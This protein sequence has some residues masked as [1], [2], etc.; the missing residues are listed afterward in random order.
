MKPNSHRAIHKHFTA[1]L[2]AGAVLLGAPLCS[3][4]QPLSTS[5]HPG[6]NFIANPFNNGGNSAAVIFPNPDPT[7]D[8]SGP[9]DNDEIR[10]W[11]CAGYIVY[12]FDSV[13]TDTTSGFVNQSGNPA[14]APILTPG[15]GFV[16]VD[17]QGAPETLV[18][19]GTAP[20]PVRPPPCNCGCGKLSLWS[21][22]TTSSPHGYQDITGSA[23]A[24]GDQ[25][26]FPLI[27]GSGGLA[28]F[29][30][31]TYSSGAWSP[32]TPTLTNGQS[33]FFYSPCC[34]N[35]V[36]VNLPPGFSLIGNPLD[37]GNNSAALLFPN[38]DPTQDYSGPRDGDELELWQC[39][40]QGYVV[41]VFDS[42]TT[43]TTTGFTNPNGIPIPA[44]ILTP[45]CGFLYLN[46]MGINES[47]VFTGCPPVAV[48]PPP[49]DCGCGK[50]SLWTPQTLNSPHSYQDVTGSAPQ[51]GDA[52]SYGVSTMGVPIPTDTY[53]GGVWS[54]NTP[55]F[56]NGES[57]FFYRP[58]PTNCVVLYDTGVDDT[59]ALLNPGSVD[60]HYT[61]INNPQGT[62][63]QTYVIVNPTAAWIPNDA[64][65]Q[66]IGPD[67]NG[68]NGISGE[69]DF[70]TTFGVPC[71]GDVVITG[72]WAAD[73]YGCIYLDT[74][75]N[76]VPGT[77]IGSAGPTDHSGFNQWHPFTVSGNLSAGTH[78][79]TFAV[80][81]TGGPTGL[82]VEFLTVTGGCCTDC[83]A[84]CT[85]P[86]PLSY[87]NSVPGGTSFL[88]NNLC[89][90]TNNTLDEILP[91]MPDSVELRTWDFVT[92]N[93]DNPQAYDAYGFVLPSPGWYD[94]GTLAPSTTTLSPGEGF[95]INNPNGPFQI[96]I[97]GCEPT[98]PPPCEPPTN[99]LSLVGRLGIGTATWTNLF[100]CP[101]PCGA[102]MSL[103]IGSGYSNYDFYRNAWHD[104]N[105]N[106]VAAPVLQIGLSAYVSIQSNSNCCPTVTNLVMNTGYN[107]NSNTV[108]NIGSADAFWWVTKDPTVPA[109]TLPRPATVITPNGAWAAAQP[110]SRWIS[111]YLTDI[112]DLNGEY[113]FQTYF[114]TATNA[115]NLVL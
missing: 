44:P 64:S 14:P 75:T 108:Y 47:V 2:L 17:N 99:G 79:L 104:L 9:H 83:C 12:V 43:D 13:T 30:T 63:P 1:A 96:V 36:T 4:A 15:C 11:N 101:P 25:V 52:V 74:S 111:S 35:S 109:A 19:T 68:G 22:Q 39:D 106:V 32:S 31:N 84:N 54:P 110:N 62:G 66:W 6:I 29:T 72:Q 3:R 112:D 60:T 41:Y 70:E 87:T 69:F 48:Y 21:P 95:I 5:V 92:Q 93:F 59:N 7:Q 90:G 58:C 88:A 113:D 80:N 89:Q 46:N 67:S 27:T 65:S 115:T 49:C 86:Y 56:T 51:D 38:P 10:I 61:L 85:Q 78:T 94:E 57:A 114:C 18:F 40:Q 16:Y 37:N 73:N 102:R 82:R 53:S 55:S 105:G 20:T 97:S 81:N 107:Q 42:V 23:P 98:C 91:N 45:G 103:W 8:Y 100:S 26:L 76:P 28:G 77:C 50:W 33:A 71:A 34:S 24:Q